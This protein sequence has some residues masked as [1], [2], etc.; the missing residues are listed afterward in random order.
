MG[1]YMHLLLS[2]LAE[3][4]LSRIALC[5]QSPR[6]RE[7]RRDIKVHP[8]GSLVLVPYQFLHE[9]P[10]VSRNS[11]RRQKPSISENLHNLDFS[12]KESAREITPA[13]LTIPQSLPCLCYTFRFLF[14]FFKFW[15]WG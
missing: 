8:E 2:G 6:S 10:R 7:G 13:W 11:K 5:R 1:T 14:S 9:D 3:S 12:P 15:C 4:I